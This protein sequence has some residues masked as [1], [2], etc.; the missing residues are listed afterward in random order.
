MEIR[1]DR[2]GRRAVPRN[3][4]F[5]KAP[6]ANVRGSYKLGYSL[7]K[8]LE[9]ISQLLANQQRRTIEQ[10]R[11]IRLVTTSDVV[12]NLVKLGLEKA[13]EE[14]RA[15]GVSDL[16]VIYRRIRSEE[17]DWQEVE[18]GLDY[19]RGSKWGS[20]GTGTIRRSE[21]AEGKTKSASRP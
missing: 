17:R 20:V 19:A 16:E 18:L 6:P 5:L 21:N 1:K 8:R 9:S 3:N 10:E 11:P 7:L 2:A 15:R 4:A 14:A 13:E 12:R